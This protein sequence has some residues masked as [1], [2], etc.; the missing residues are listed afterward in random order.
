MIAINS[1]STL[2]SES[3]GSKAFHCVTSQSA[4]SKLMIVALL[5]HSA[6]RTN[7]NVRGPLVSEVS[8]GSALSGTIGGFLLGGSGLEPS[9]GFASGGLLDGGAPPP[10]P[11]PPLPPPPLPP[12]PLP[13]PPPPPPP[14]GGGTSPRLGVFCGKSRGSGARGA[15]VSAGA[16]GPALLFPFPE[17][18]GNEGLASSGF[19]SSSGRTGGCGSAA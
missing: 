2:V 9:F 14:A 16:R 5:L 17:P 11:P 10:F 18:G 15:A 6:P 19:F 12:P 8:R 3:P 1:T 13:P 4:L 7:G